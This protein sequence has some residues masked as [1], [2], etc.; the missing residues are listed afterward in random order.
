V[1]EARAERDDKLAVKMRELD[2]QEAHFT[3]ELVGSIFG[4]DS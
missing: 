4:C 1:K 3:A 2:A